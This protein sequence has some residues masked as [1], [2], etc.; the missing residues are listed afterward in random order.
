MYSDASGKIGMGALCGT[1]W[2][3]QTWSK[4]FLDKCKPSI[5]HL[6]L[7]GVTA[8]VLTWI[9]RFKNSRVILFC[10][11]K[12]VV[13]MINATT[14]SCKNCM[15]LIRMIVLKG[16]FENVRIFARHVKGTKNDLADSLSRNKLSYFHQLC[17]EQERSMDTDPTNIP[18][19]LWP[20]E[21]LWKHKFYIFVGQRKQKKKFSMQDCESSSS[22]S[23][24]SSRISIEHV[25]FILEKIKNQQVR[26]STAKNYLGIW[27]QLNKFVINL[28]C[29]SYISWECKTALFGAYLIDQGI[30]SSTLKSYF[31]AI[32][33]ILRQ[34][35]YEWDDKKAVLNSLIKG[36][37]VENDKLKVRLPIP[38]GLF[39]MLLFELERLYVEENIQPYLEAMYKALFCLA[40]YGMMRVGELTKGDHTL[41]A[42]NIHVSEKNDKIMMVL[43]TSK[44]QG[45]ES[46]PQKIK[47]SAVETNRKNKRIFCPVKTVIKFMKIRGTYYDQDE[48]LFIFKD[49]SPV[50]PNNF[51]STLRILLD[52]ISLDSSLYDIHS[53]RAGRTC[54]LA[55]YGYS[56]EQ[57]KI[58]GRWRSNA[59]YRYLKNY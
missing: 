3:Y 14:T 20:V 50:K 39:E 56:V 42:C 59:V 6:E 57:I 5:E 45:R 53:F 1:S 10:D 32:K 24:Q 17:E 36:C 46:R 15:V 55:K 16:L 7:F 27:R 18:E 49:N 33:Y 37:E 40:Y 29:K 52:R 8:A 4:T 34:D 21:K 13:D 12:S 41:K 19:A 28:D 30:Q 58:L 23:S 22:T 11:N 38:K 51:R 48:Q 31:S 54:D 25:K 47:V 44:T 35:G 26:D 43:Y 9:G 2:M